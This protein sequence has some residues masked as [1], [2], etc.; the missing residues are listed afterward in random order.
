MPTTFHKWVHP[1]TD[2]QRVYIRGLSGVPSWGAKIFLKQGTK[3][4]SDNHHD[5]NMEIKASPGVI[6]CSRDTLLDRV[7]WSLKELFDSKEYISTFEQIW[8]IAV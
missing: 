7:D 8:E 1:S 4:V 5:W 6:T 3:R 2:E